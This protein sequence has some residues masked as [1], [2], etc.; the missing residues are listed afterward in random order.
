[1]GSMLVD[2]SQK[3]SGPYSPCIDDVIE[4]VSQAYG[5]I[6]GAIIFSGMGQ[7]GLNGARKMREKG[8]QVWAQ[9]V[10]TC[11]NA[12]MPQA[13]I[14]GGQADFIGSPEELAQKLV[15]LLTVAS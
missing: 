13:I 5:D 2:H 15:Q 12:S 3:W 10:D 9:S 4:S 11:A 6:A 14:E 7:D 1:D 8:G